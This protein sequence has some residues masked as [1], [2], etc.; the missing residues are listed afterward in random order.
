MENS[1]K[2]WKDSSIFLFGMTFGSALLLFAGI[3]MLVMTFSPALAALLTPNPDS[4]YTLLPVAEDRDDRFINVTAL[5][6]KQLY[7]ALPTVTDAEAG[8]WIIIPSINVKVP[9]ALSPTVSDDDVIKTLE[10]GAALYPNGI[11][12]GRI[13][14]TFI[15]AHSTGNPWHGPYRFAFLKV[16]QIKP[17]HTI[18]LDYKGT[19]YTYRV[20]GSDIVKPDPNYRV[21]SD[22][23]VP[24][25]TLM[26]CWPLWSTS[27]RM[28]VR[29]ELTNITKLT[30]TP[31][32]I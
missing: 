5:A 32:S 10:Q 6:G 16:N 8:D 14:N 28:L 25:I 13:G 19:R 22:R 3:G 26:A 2:T 30:P 12:P 9:L 31:Q 15:S 17:G 23:P 29:G 24:T 27:Q 1:Q 20:T 21:I 4:R 7:P 11:A 18:H